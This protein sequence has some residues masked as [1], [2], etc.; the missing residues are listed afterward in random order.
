[1]QHIGVEESLD[2]EHGEEE[3]FVRAI[4]REDEKCEWLTTVRING[5]LKVTLKID[6]GGRLQGA[7]RKT[8]IIC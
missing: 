5:S 7:K 1:M 3:F 4:G 6:S 8:Q 2:S